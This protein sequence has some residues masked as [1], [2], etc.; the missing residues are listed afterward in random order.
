MTTSPTTAPTVAPAMVLAET[1]LPSSFVSAAI[2][3]VAVARL[4]TVV[5]LVTVGS[6]L[7]PRRLESGLEI[8][9]STSTIVDITHFGYF[10]PS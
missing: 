1:P 5:E 10:S 3:L 9:V 4:V 6:V 2:E 7:I 8:E